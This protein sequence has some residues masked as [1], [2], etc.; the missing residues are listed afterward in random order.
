M[1]EKLVRNAQDSIRQP[2]IHFFH[3]DK[4]LRSTRHWAGAWGTGSEGS[5]TPMLAVIMES[6][7]KDKDTPVGR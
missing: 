1:N 6:A 2:L 3:P 4:S 7:R 5:V